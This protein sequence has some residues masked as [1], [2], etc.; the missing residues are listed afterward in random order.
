MC[1]VKGGEWCAVCDVMWCG[2]M[3]C[4]GRGGVALG[5]VRQRVSGWG[6]RWERVWCSG[7]GWVGYGRGKG[8][9]VTWDRLGWCW[10]TWGGCGWWRMGEGV[11]LRHGYGYGWRVDGWLGGLKCV[12]V[13]WACLKR[14]GV[15][16][17]R[18]LGVGPIFQPFKTHTYVSRVDYQNGMRP[19]CTCALCSRSASESKRRR[20]AL[21]P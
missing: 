1:D 14:R 12:G 18:A 20:S 21:P 6:G 11:R 7:Q 17:C 16:E 4:D 13:C 19:P 9:W 2:A 15:L 10:V 3:W 8:G 5:G